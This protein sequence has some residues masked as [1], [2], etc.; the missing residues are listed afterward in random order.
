MIW[1]EVNTPR[2]SILIPVY[3]REVMV[4]PCIESALNQTAG[5]LEVVLVDNASTDDT[6][7]VCQEYARQD[8]RVRIFRNKQNLGPV[9]NWQRCFEEARGTFGKILFSDD[10]LRPD[11]VARTIPYIE[12][13]RV[14]F[15]FTAAEIGKKPGEGHVAYRWGKTQGLFE[16][17]K[18]IRAALLT[19]N[20][21]VSPGA[22][23]FRMEDLRKNLMLKLPKMHDYDFLKHG[24]GPDMLL[25]LLTATRYP[26]VAHIPEPL[27]FFRA[28]KS[29]ITIK[30]SIK[31][32]QGYTHAA[33]W[34]AE[35]YLNNSLLFDL[36]ARKWLF[37]MYHE[38]KPLSWHKYVS[39]Y[40]S[41]KPRPPLLV[42]PKI[43]FEVTLRRL[44]R[45]IV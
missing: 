5:D 11:F 34:F 38:R 6:W 7:D 33:T 36:L 40:T 4:G 35:H 32:S 14:G 10:L 3:N 26:L 28:H 21:P 15:A 27:V 25:Y 17:D 39:R 29:S 19:G 9:R 2:V 12:D 18:F 8:R 24:A 41:L 43:L 20:V 23:I 31:V 44:K 22:A 30:A 45:L 37:S 13:G 42:L 16:S 1:S